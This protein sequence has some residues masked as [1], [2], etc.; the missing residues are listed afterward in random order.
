MSSCGGFIQEHNAYLSLLP[1]PFLDFCNGEQK[2]VVLGRSWIPTS[3]ASYK[4]N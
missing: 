3:K 2:H 1:K 4:E